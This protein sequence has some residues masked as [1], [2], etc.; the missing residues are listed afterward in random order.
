VSRDAIQKSVRDALSGGRSVLLSGP[1]GIGKSTVLGGIVEWVRE[2]G[3]RVLYS[4]PAQA[5]ARLPFVVLIDLL[6]PL[7]PT[8]FD[9]LPPVPRRALDAALLRGEV[10]D[11][12]PDPLAVRLGVLHVLRDLAAR[13]PSVVVVDDVQWVDPSSAE[14][15]AFLARR[16]PGPGLRVVAAAR[17]EP[18][19]VARFLPLLPAGALQVAVGPLADEALVPL[20]SSRGGAALSRTVAVEICR[21]TQGNPLF[22]LEIASALA[23]RRV[24]PSVGEPL[25]VPKELRELMC[26]R[27]AVL[28]EPVRST[29]L[30]ASAAAR[31]TVTLLAQA[32]CVDVVAGLTSAEQAGVA[33]LHGDGSVVFSHP[34]MQAVVYGEASLVERMG[35]HARLAGAIGEPVEHARHLALASVV[36]DEALAATLIAAAGVARRRGAA[37]MAA[38]L[39]RLSAE[40]T[41]RADTAA[42]AERLL[43]A[44]WHFY[45]AYLHDESR[46]IAQ[47]VLAMDVPRPTRARA[48]IVLLELTG[49]AIGQAGELADAAI[50]DAAG[51][52]ALEA[53]AA[54]HSA[55][56]H[57][58]VGRFDVALGE[59]RRAVAAAEFA[60]DPNALVRSLEAL[61]A[62][63]EVLG[64]DEYP[65]TLARALQLPGPTGWQI[66]RMH[67]QH[68]TREQRFAE[69]R[70]ASREAVRLAEE[71][72]GLSEIC[73]A[74]DCALVVEIGSGDYAVALEFARRLAELAEED[75]EANLGSRLSSLARAELVGGSAERARDLA[76]R[77]LECAQ[78]AADLHASIANSHLLGSALLFL[79]DVAGAVEA[80]RQA[81]ELTLSCGTPGWLW[82]P[83]ASDLAEA[84]L[85]AGDAEG[86]RAVVEEGR[87]AAEARADT[88]ILAELTRVEALVLAAD[89][90]LDA[91]VEQLERL[92]VRQR[93]RSPVEVVRPLVALAGV[94]RRCRRRGAAQALLAEA[95]RI[96]VLSGAAPWLE[97]VDAELARVEAPRQSGGEESLTPVEARVSAMVIDGATNRDVAAAL[98]ISIKTV[99]STLSRIYR[100]LG[101]RSRIELIKAH[102]GIS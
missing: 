28:P 79:G 10:T 27:L 33:Q 4:S 54:Y 26:E 92:V 68:L 58:A 75:D 16:L 96:C 67:A 74:L 20:L 73:L 19:E 39:A 21:V 78:R 13:D 52:P 99:E 98:S 63:Q 11:V 1:A 88:V 86:A 7:P 80:L 36:E 23:R 2:T 34:L 64:D 93:G 43:A 100:K 56:R 30:V 61:L 101:V 60:A 51:D 47:A 91:A 95:R 29:L 85:L 72:G 18:G 57:L 50:A 3:A 94:E 42:K 48:R 31:P 62:A 55:W 49:R 9:G 17:G 37:G 89:G 45:A 5:D 97:V 70:V 81:R 24:R 102:A 12:Q 6:S 14:V 35:A 15:L 83:W 76:A 38:E 41:P 90:R 71:E 46:Q 69:A 40:R 66:H 82:Y 65:A 44:A 32:G 8:A 77:G 25:P 87:A 59:A 84:L 22:A 53:A